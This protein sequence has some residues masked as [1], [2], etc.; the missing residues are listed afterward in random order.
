[1]TN[2]TEQQPIALGGVTPILRVANLAASIDYYT[3]KLG[4][5]VNWGFPD[6][7]KSFFASISRGRC[8]LF[9]SVGDQGHPGSW[10]WIDGVDVEALHAE[11][12]TAGAN[13]RNPPTNYVWA[14]E[15]QVEDLDGNILRF[16]SD[17][18]EGEPEGQWLD[19]NGDR[20]IRLPDGTHQKSREQ[21]TGNRD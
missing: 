5:K 2:Q 20:W 10:V 19:M 21:G 17:P 1:M 8:N 14:L 7:G 15:M 9:L 13:I 4:F 16:G 12:E 11:F 6:E 3:T 18:K